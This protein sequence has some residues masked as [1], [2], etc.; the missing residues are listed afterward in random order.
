MILH[1]VQELETNELLAA[2][3]AERFQYIMIDE[4]QD[5]S[6]SQSRLVE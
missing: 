3:L 2:E 6:N 4:F 1:V 5:L